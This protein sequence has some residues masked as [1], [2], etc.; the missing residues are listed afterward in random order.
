MPQ[1][2]EGYD[3]LTIAPGT[4]ER[5]PP[6]LIGLPHAPDVANPHAEFV[7]EHIVEQVTDL[8]EHAAAD[9]GAAVE[10]LRDTIDRPA[11]PAIS[12]MGAYHADFVAE[13]LGADQAV[14]LP[15]LPEATTVEVH[16]SLERLRDTMS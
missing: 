5:P 4:T 2:P 15:T 16:E 3:A 8:P 12:E 7:A 1:D 13:H 9:V 11:T 6:D 10:R 14:D